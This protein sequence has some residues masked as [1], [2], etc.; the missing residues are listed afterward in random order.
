CFG[1]RLRDETLTHE[2]ILEL[3][4][5]AAL[6]P[7]L[8]DRDAHELSGGQEQRL[9]IARALANQP[10][11]LLLD[12][13]TSAL[14]PIATHKVEDILLHLRDTSGLTLVWVSHSVE[15]AR[16]VADRV[17]LLEDGRVSRFGTVDALLDHERGD[18]HTLAFARGVD[19]NDAVGVSP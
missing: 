19:D 2:R 16:R 6:E 1:P 7:D 11:V 15:Q 18:A 9:A 14:D 8:I 10:S 3:M 13:P 5:Q 4:A 17:L 12:E